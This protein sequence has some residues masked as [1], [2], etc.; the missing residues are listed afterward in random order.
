MT[1]LTFPTNPTL[2]QQYAAPNGIQYVFDGV[3]WIVETVASSSAAVTNSVQDRVAHMFVT[4]DHTGIAF[5][6]TAATNVMSAEVTAVNGDSLVNGVHELTLESTGATTFPTLTVPLEDN[7]NPIGTGQVLKFSD[8]TQQAIIFGPVSTAG[9]TSAERVIIQGAPGYTGTAGEGGD[10][11]VWAGPG[12]SA[13][14][15]GGDIKV[16]AGQGIGS[17]NGGYLNF[18]AGDSNTGNGGYINIESGQSNTYGNGGDITICAH[19]GGDIKLRTHN[20]V[21]SQDWLFG[22]NGATTFPT[23]GQIAN[24]PDGVGASDNSWFV[25]PGGEDGNGGVSSQDGQQYI[26][27]NNN[28]PVEI[29]TSYGTENESIWRFG[30]DGDL[31]LPEG[32]DILD[33]NGDS[34]L[35]GGSY[36]PDDSGNWNDPTVNTVAAALDELAAKVAALENFEIDGGNANTPAL[37]E[38]LID[39]NGA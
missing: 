36:T 8:S 25:T 14:G 23:G 16:R 37:G 17:G 7:A 35:G 19:N 38:L 3:K 2:G 1:V 21:T 29:G 11:Y 31:T 28:L 18:Q 24:Y 33:S 39:G 30:R 20:S 5:T 26:Q 9:A 27:I 32:G 4:G 15:Q 6:Y 34:V 12:G 22:A 10:V 13:N